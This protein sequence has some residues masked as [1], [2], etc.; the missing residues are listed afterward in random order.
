M[1]RLFSRD[2]WPIRSKP[3]DIFGIICCCYIIQF[4]QS[5]YSFIYRQLVIQK[6]RNDWNTFT[7]G[8][9]KKDRDGLR[10]TIFDVVRRG[11]N[12]QTLR[13]IL[14][15]KSCIFLVRSPWYPVACTKVTIPRGATLIGELVNFTLVL[16]TYNWWLQKVTWWKG[17]TRCRVA[18]TM[19]S[20]RRKTLTN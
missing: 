2:V 3:A 11:T 1:Y 16:G 12:I 5:Y 18:E 19:P 17:K 20:G 10:W 6:I 4:M 13:L 8:T 14:I 15:R 7:S 9:D